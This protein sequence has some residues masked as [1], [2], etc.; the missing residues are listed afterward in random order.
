MPL[1]SQT[2][3][4]HVMDA[5]E[6]IVVNNGPT[7]LAV[8]AEFLETTPANATAALEMAID[9]G[10]VATNGPDYVVS[11][12][13]CRFARIPEHKAAVLRIVIEQ[14]RP[15]VS[16]RD[17]LLHTP[18]MNKAA[19][20]SK[21]VCGLPATRDI[22]KETLI[23]LGT[24]SRALIP[25]GAGH[26]QL[27]AT[28]LVSALTKIAGSCTDLVQAEL[29]IRDQLG[30]AASAVVSRDNVI[31][32]L[33]DALF[34]ANQR[35]PDGAVQQAGNAVESHIME[36]AARMNPPVNVAGA[37]GIGQKLTRFQNPRRLAMKLIHVGSYLGAV[38][39]AADHGAADPDIP[40]ATWQIRDAT[41]LEYVFVACSFVAAT[42]LIEQNKPPEI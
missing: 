35:D 11:S 18:D 21:V 14:Y 28:S 31:L 5:V 24:Y 6:A 40:G 17:Q 25:S 22:I 30:P 32:P 42:V 15:F 10:L 39:N 1:A 2:T 34:K 8:I 33:A 26:F 3:A 19:Q 20:S 7:A 4:D 9:L 12:P 36:M 23:S 13:L 38:R 37:N 29:R 41:G 16:F 27:D